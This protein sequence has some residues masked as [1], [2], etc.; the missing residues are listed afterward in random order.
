MAI[1]SAIM[2][3]DNSVG[4]VYSDMA[5]IDAV[6]RVIRRRRAHREGPFSSRDVGFEC[7]LHSSN[8]FGIPLL[9]KTALLPDIVFDEFLSYTGDVDL[10]ITLGK[11]GTSWHH[12][13][14]LIAN[15]YHGSNATRNLHHLSL[16]QYF[17]IARRH[18]YHLTAS[19]QFQMRFS[20]I[21]TMLLK[22]LFLFY[23]GLRER[24]CSS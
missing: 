11:R 19:H 8:R 17:E 23:A 24:K 14:F 2:D 15:R 9:T 18:E 3:A 7:I 4:V 1:A 13:D 12:P 21:R 20:N 6:D 10:A 22:A 5:Y 16:V